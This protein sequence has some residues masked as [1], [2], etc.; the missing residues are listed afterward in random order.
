ME[1]KYSLP[2][3]SSISFKK[4]FVNLIWKFF[5][6]FIYP[7][8][9]RSHFIRRKILILFGAKV[10][11]NVRIAS[12]CKIDYPFN[13][14]ISENSS[15]GSDCYLQALDKILI[16]ENVCISDKVSILTGSHDLESNNFKLI[17]SKINI[18]DNVWLSYGCCIL[19]GV[20][21][22]HNAVVGAFAVVS[23]NVDK[24]SIVTGNPAN[25][26]GIRKII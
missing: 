9:F 24:N 17:T 20:T 22:N 12:S 10:A 26:R 1:I 11:K 8:T 19:K 5:N 4:K 18:Q 23:K 16:G 3:K 15:L 21:V 7:F 13:L 25:H 6:N 2:I 14:T